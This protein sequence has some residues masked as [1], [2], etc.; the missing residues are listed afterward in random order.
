MVA[1]AALAGLNFWRVTFEP[2]L[3]SV[4]HGFP[5]YYV[6]ARLIVEGRWGP[7]V[8]DDAWFNAEVMALTDDRVG[9]VYGA[10]PPIASLLLLPLAGLDMA[11][12]R[13]AWLVLNLI[14]LLLA[15]IAILSTTDRVRSPDFVAGLLGFALI[16]PPL[17]E[18]FRLAQAYVFLLF[19]YALAY[20]GFSRRRSATTGL[21]L[22]TAA[23]TKVSGGPLWL[24]PAARG[25]WRDVL[26]S[27]LFAA[28][29]VIAS[30]LL[31]GVEGWTGYFSVLPDHLLGKVL[32]PALAFQTTSSFFQHLFAADARWSLQPIW[33]QPWLAVVLTIGVSV[34]ALGLTLWRSRRSDFDLAFAAAATLS[35]VLQPLAEEYHYTLLLLPLAVMAS[36][37]FREPIVRIDVAWLL[38]VVS[39]LA[40]AWPYKLDGLTGSWAV[41]MGYP[42]LYGGWLLWAWLYVRMKAR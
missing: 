7:N 26:A 8:Y 16:Y 31:T 13:A 42:R 22:G 24:L 18:N 2:S 39:L 23:A 1:L 9:E 41:L 5:V 35:V 28:L 32:P 15:L 10:N 3:R 14:L 40:I 21:A 17:R 19:L 30:L 37:V 12:A 34:A 4:T 27:G 36:R 6:S 11:D 25:R 33:H 20:W 38:L 29:F